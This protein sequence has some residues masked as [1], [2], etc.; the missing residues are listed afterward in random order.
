MKSPRS[1][2]GST[3]GVS[4]G[5]EGAVL[6]DAPALAGADADAGAE[7]PPEG[8]A[9]VGPFVPPPQA[10][11]A[12]TSVVSRR[13]VL[14]RIAGG[15]PTRLLPVRALGAVILSAHIHP[16]GCPPSPPLSEVPP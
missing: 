11:V 1:A 10:A 3:S 5:V 16:A 4:T 8:A 9:V 15:Y 2:V 13:I 12:R 7:P 6:G 14:V